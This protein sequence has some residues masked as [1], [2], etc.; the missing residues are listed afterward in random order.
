[1]SRNCRIFFNLLLE[2]KATNT[3][4]PKCH[5]LKLRWINNLCVIHNFWVEKVWEAWQLRL[6]NKFVSLALKEIQQWIFR[7]L[8]WGR[9]CGQNRPKIGFFRPFLNELPVSCGVVTEHY[10]SGSYLCW[11]VSGVYLMLLSLLYFIKTVECWRNW[12]GRQILI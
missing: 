9:W 11:W 8:N 10:S 7:G 1:M 4:L 6:R 12:G 5:I 3:T 2:E